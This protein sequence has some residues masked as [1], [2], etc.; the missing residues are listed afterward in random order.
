MCTFIRLT[1][2][3][4]QALSEVKAHLLWEATS[5]QEGRTPLLSYYLAPAPFMRIIPLAAVWILRWVI[6]RIKFFFSF[7]IY[8][9]IF[10]FLKT[11]MTCLSFVILHQCGFYTQR[12]EEARPG[13]KSLE[14]TTIMTDSP[15]NKV[16]SPILFYRHLVVEEVYHTIRPPMIPKLKK[17]KNTD[18]DATLSHLLLL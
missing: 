1:A 14:Q 16:R 17:T 6:M 5:C 13:H 8:D 3:Q 4:P 7:Q 9:I 15:G 11:I 12:Q 2:L 18:T 10:F